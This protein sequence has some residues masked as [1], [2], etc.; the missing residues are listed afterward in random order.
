MPAD[1]HADLEPPNAISF[2]PAETTSVE[3]TMALGARLA[4]ALEAG[5]I[6]ALYGDLGAGKT[7]FV[8]GM[9]R[10]LGLPP[11]EVRSPTFTILHAYDGGRLPLYH[12][13]AYRVQRPSEFY[14]LGYEDYFYGDGITCIEWPERVETLIP[15]H[16]LRLRLTHEGPD[17][18]RIE[19]YVPE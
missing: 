13:D 16:A 6:V 9:A 18:R 11:A 17:R 14:E 19:H 2:L 7:H 8:K 15:D 1:A 10:A 4:E 12:F 5:A 3:E